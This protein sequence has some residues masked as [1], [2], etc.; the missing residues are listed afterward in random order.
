VLTLT[1]SLFALSAHAAPAQ[2]AEDCL[3]DGPTPA[4]VGLVA[5]LEGDAVDW[6]HWQ[7][8]LAQALDD[9][10]PQTAKTH[11]AR[12]ADGIDA[13][14]L[15]ATFDVD[16]VPELLAILTVT[17]PQDPLQQLGRQLLTA[18]LNWLDGSRLDNEDLHL[19]LI[20]QG[21]ALIARSHVEAVDTVEVLHTARTLAAVNRTGVIRND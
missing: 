14:F 17:N 19:R 2:T 9:D 8:R 21:E 7:D 3:V 18:E 20:M 6:R 16:G 12:L 13:F 10:A 11:A 4:C 5:R 15:P 1:A